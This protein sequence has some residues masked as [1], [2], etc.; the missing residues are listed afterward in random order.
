[1]AYYWPQYGVAIEVDDDPYL[2]P[3]DE[4]AFPDAVV[5]HVTTDVIC[6]PNRFRHSP[7]ISP[8]STTSNSTQTS[9]S[10]ST[11]DVSCS[12]C[13]LAPIRPR[14]R[15]SIPLRMPHERTEAVEPL[16][17]K[18]RK[19]LGIVCLAIA[20]ALS[21]SA[22]TPGSQSLSP[23]RAPRS[24]RQRVSRA[25]KSRTSSMPSSATT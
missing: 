4:E 25:K 11:R 12:T 7:T 20:C 6:D 14:S 9:T 15:A 19:R 24:Q 10:S 13:S 23:R 2:L 17:S 1:M 8:T 16:G 3:F 22:F 5:Y 18:H 21:P